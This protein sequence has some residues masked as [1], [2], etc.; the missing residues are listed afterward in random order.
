MFIIKFSIDFIN[1]KLTDILKIIVSQI[2]AKY[3]NS[4]EIQHQIATDNYF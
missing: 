3:H 4:L 1:I 2:S